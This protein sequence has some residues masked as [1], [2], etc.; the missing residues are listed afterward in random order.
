MIKIIV[1]STCDLTKEEAVSMSLE[2]LPLTINFSDEI[3]R[4]GIDLTPAEFYKKLR[5]AKALPTT[6][7]IN[8]A[9][10]EQA[11]I[12]HIE[13]GDDIIVITL[14]SKLSATLNSAVIAAQA[15]CPERIHVVD[16]LSAS[17]GISLLIKQAV[18]M[19]DAGKYSIT[20][21]VRTLRALVPRI[22]VYAVLDTLKYLK[23]G[24]R[25]SG[26]AALIGGALGIS[27]I[28]KVIDGRVESIGKVRS[29]R[30]GMRALLTY[31]QEYG[32]DI[33]YGVAFGNADD[34]Q[35]M[36]RYIEYLRPYLEGAEIFTG[37]LGSVIG[38]HTGPGVVGMAFF[39]KEQ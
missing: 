10:F 7:Q 12:P 35:K 13:K 38:A 26:G 17:M 1:D 21:I 15:V 3:Y 16:S 37:N 4:D 34:W 28:V 24:G 23:K 2:V 33:A 8:P 18:K 6:S 19:R 36:M 9:Q 20:E 11:F 30:A 25:L 5:Q 29:E 32:I 31:V 39:G 22:N 27:P 14:S